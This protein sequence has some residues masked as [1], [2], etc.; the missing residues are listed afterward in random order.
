M[1]TT[2]IYIPT[3]ISSVDF[4]PAKVLPRIYFY[5]G[6]KN[7]LPYYIEGR[8]GSNVGSIQFTEFPY[9]DHYSGSTPDASSKSLL[10]N[11]EATPYGE[12]P[13]ESLY[14]EYWESY[15][16]LLYN[17]KTRLLNCSAI[18]PLS[19]Y[20]NLELNDI[21]N[22]RGNYYHLRAINDYNLS[23]GECTL[24]LLGPVI[25]DTLNQKVQ[26]N[27]IITDGLQLYL[28]AG[29]TNS[30]P[31]T[32]TIWNSL[33]GGES[34]GS[35][36]SGPTYSTEYGGSIVFDGVNDFVSVNRLPALN[37]TPNSSFTMTV[38][39]KVNSMSA[40]DRQGTIFAR[41]STGGSFG[42]GMSR[43]TT[44]NYNWTV[45]SRA[46]G[47]ITTTIPYTIG[48]VECI[49]F[50][51]T[52]T[53]QY[54]YKNGVLINTQNTS[55]GVGGAFDNTDYAMFNSNAV[56]SGTSGWPA[57]SVYSALIYNRAL[58]DAE[59]AYNYNIS[60]VRFGL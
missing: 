58:T 12:T 13:T 38:W 45:G 28:D 20:F 22:F 40:S 30:Y 44:N 60:K 34:S 17:P 42:I 59:V 39:A 26:F 57:G 10:F 23:T 37:F 21:V 49:T 41:G 11:N 3:F 54:V 14:T 56:P 5:N 32:G 24:Q 4:K 16:Q 6:T 19:E 2:P 43:G 31:G 51:Y 35:L 50:V 29:N 52:P 7:S 18:I 25:S 36:R 55:A 27:G 8:E 53:F 46:V 9:F 1:S 48:N 33:T 15:V 47:A